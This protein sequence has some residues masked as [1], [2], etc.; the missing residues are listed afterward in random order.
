MTRLAHKLV[1]HGFELFKGKTAKG[2]VGSF[3]LRI[4]STALGFI[5]SIL[6]ARLL[7]V[8]GYGVYS[9]A[10]AWTNL[11]VIPAMLGLN[12]LL[13][14]EVATYNT[15]AAW[16]RIRALLRWSNGIVVLVSVTIAVIAAI[17]FWS[18]LDGNA[19]SLALVIALASLPFSALTALRQ[20]ALLGF[21]HVV[22]GQL[23]EMLLRPSLLIVLVFGAYALLGEKFNALWTVALAV[24]AICIS[25]AVGAWL[26]QRVL[27]RS[28]RH[29]QPE[30]S[31]RKW[32]GSA[33]PFLLIAGMFVINNR[34]D[35]IMLGILKGQTSVGIYAIVVKVASLVIFVF[36]SVNTALAPSI[37][38][39]HS[40]R[41]IRGLEFAIRRSTL[42][43]S[44]V[45]LPIEFALI[46]FGKPM[47]SVFGPDFGQGYVALIILSLGRLANVTTGSTS[48]LL[49]MTGHERDTATAVA[50]S[51][52]LNILLNAFLIPRW[53]LVGAA[54]ATACGTVVGNVLIAVFV[55]RRLGFYS[56]L[57]IINFRRAT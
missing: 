10:F 12:Q 53:D 22:T 3:A 8:K 57:G 40:T 25:F 1:S 19:T 13:I 31:V 47:L 24:L 29:A 28:V 36:I 45:T 37:A 14:R 17:V 54:T 34:T 27:P 4:G 16:G 38:R 48:L 44:L 26:L 6:L 46:I 7:G 2:A 41:N 39:L 9:Y 18:L 51:A 5:I 30:Y 21:R 43:T 15:Q 49:N 23:P 56:M 55:Y 50:V 35:I 42:L 33:F 11:L 20:G 52:V 32:L